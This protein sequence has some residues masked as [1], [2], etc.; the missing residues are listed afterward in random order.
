MLLVAIPGSLTFLE[1]RAALSF[2]TGAFFIT[3]FL[4]LLA[5]DLTVF[6]GKDTLTFALVCFFGESTLTGFVTVCFFADS[7]FT[8]FFTESAFADST[9]SF[10]GSTT[11]FLGE[12][13]VVFALATVFF[14]LDLDPAV[15]GAF[16]TASFFVAGFFAGV[17]S[18]F[19]A[20][21]TMVSL[22]YLS[23]PIHC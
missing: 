16:S 4:T 14:G 10:F 12:A 15:G 18:D 17:A 9:F 3:V 1:T 21:L 20:S 6:F 7:T 22:N 8:A 23:F 13:A 5:G 2:F 19:G 11:F